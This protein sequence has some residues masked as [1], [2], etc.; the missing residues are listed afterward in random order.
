[1]ADYAFIKNGS[2]VNVACFEDPSDDLLNMF[3]EEF[4]L[5]LIL[6]AT[7]TTQ[8]GGT[9]DGTK[10]WLPQPFPSWV[11]DEDT[12]Q[13]VPPLPYPTDQKPY[14]WDES[15]VSWKAI[16]VTETTVTPSSEPDTPSN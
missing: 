4:S 3:K 9:Y 10:F 1:M 14:E 8:T 12:N 2:V 13:W 6:P 16:E 15:T 7:A 5:D 11:K